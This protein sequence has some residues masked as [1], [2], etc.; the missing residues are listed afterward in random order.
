MCLFNGV[1]AEAGSEGHQAFH[2]P[3]P[4]PNYMF[5]FLHLRGEIHRPRRSRQTAQH[6]AGAWLSTK[7]RSAGTSGDVGGPTRHRAT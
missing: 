1:R 2:G 5:Q 4:Q 3:N 7:A 6:H